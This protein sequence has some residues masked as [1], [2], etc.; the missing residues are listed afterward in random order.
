[1]AVVYGV[2]KPCQGG[3][4]KKNQGGRIV[5]AATVGGR[6]PLGPR[7]R[8]PNP[9]TFREH[10][11]MN[12][13]TERNSRSDQ[14]DITSHGRPK[15]KG[16]DHANLVVDS[17]SCSADRVF[18]CVGHRCGPASGQ[19]RYSRAS[20][21]ALSRKALGSLPPH[22]P[23][24]KS[25]GGFFLVPQQDMIPRTKRTH[26]ARSMIFPK[27]TSPPRLMLCWENSKELP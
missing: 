3:L 8:S 15:T 5:V 9:K 21:K 17:A 20:H 2:K 24:C 23:A 13:V 26:P 10:D 11:V 22:P 1:M 6:P 12:K 7:G 16:C 18:D 25:A 14:Q 4:D 27:N 19:R